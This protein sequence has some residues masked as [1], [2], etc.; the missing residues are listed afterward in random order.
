MSL[1]FS[2]QEIREAIAGVA[3][4]LW[5]SGDE[6]LI[7]FVLESV[8]KVITGIFCIGLGEGA[9]CLLVGLLMKQEKL[10]FEDGVVKDKNKAGD[11]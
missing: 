7:E 6:G 2:A 10:D 5:E 9:L 11:S 4:P 1:V 8:T 3:P